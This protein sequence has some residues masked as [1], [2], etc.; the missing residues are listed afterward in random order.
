ME[1][2]STWE[3]ILVG[4]VAIFVIL[5]FRPGIRG[6]FQHAKQVEQKDWKGFLLPIAVVFLFV[7]LLLAIA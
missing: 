7:M 2:M 3:M 5:W 1:A 6:A 4:L